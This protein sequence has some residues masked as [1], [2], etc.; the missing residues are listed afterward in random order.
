MATVAE[1][2]QQAREA[3]GLQI[4]DVAEV[5]KIRSDH[6]RALEA[7]NYEVFSAPVYIRGFVRTYASVLKLDVAQILVA[8]NKELSH[9]GQGEPSLSPPAR[10]PVDKAM[11]QLAKFSRRIALRVALGAL[12]LAAGFVVYLVW[13]HNQ[14]RDPLEGLSPGLYEMQASAETLPLPPLQ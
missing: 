1:Q 12:V 8:L 2:L 9:S 7:G 10:G 11:F 3:Q 6:L 5:T 14:K 4:N 13:D